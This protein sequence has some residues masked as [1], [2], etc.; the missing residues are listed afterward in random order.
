MATEIKQMCEVCESCQELTPR[1]GPEKLKQ[2]ENG[3]S[4]W[5]KRGMDILEIKGKQYLVT[6]D[7]FTNFI[8]CDLL[9]VTTSTQIITK[10]KKQ[11]ARFGIPKCIVSDGGSQFT[12]YEFKTFVE[13]WG[14]IQLIS[15]PGHQQ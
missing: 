8:E 2:Q 4:P 7:Y 3:N 6:V 13:Q 1:N 10:L 5:E 15:S 11:F 9:T 14:M 12:S